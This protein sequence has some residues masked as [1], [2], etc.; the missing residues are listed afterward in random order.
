MIR[1][2]D[3]PTALESALELRAEIAE[4]AARYLVRAVR[5]RRCLFILLI[6]MAWSHV[7]TIIW[8]N[9]GGGWLGKIKTM[10]DALLL[11][12]SIVAAFNSWF[13]QCRLKD[14]AA[15]LKEYEDLVCRLDGKDAVARERHHD[16]DDS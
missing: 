9:I 13:C 1:V 8:P 3:E 4:R 2:F 14:A 7:I 6:A 12:G 16:L 5:L 15:K 11:G 10:I